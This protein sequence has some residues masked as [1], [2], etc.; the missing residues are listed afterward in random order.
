MRYLID[1]CSAETYTSFS[2]DS[3]KTVAY[4]KD[5]QRKL[6]SKVQSGDILISY[7]MKL[8]RW[9][10]YQEVVRESHDDPKTIGKPWVIY[11]GVKTHVW[12]QSV[13]RMLPI[14]LPEIWDKLSFTKG[15]TRSEPAIGP[16]RRSLQE[17]N[18]EDGKLLIRL[19]NEQQRLQWPY[20][21]NN[22][23]WEAQ[24]KSTPRLKSK[25]KM[26]KQRGGNAPTNRPF[27]YWVEGKRMVEPRHDYLQERF[28]EYLWDQ[29]INPK[30]DVDFIDVQYSASGRTTFCEIKPTENVPTRYAIRAAI[31]QLLEHRFKQSP[32]AALEIV[33]GSKPGQEE[34]DFVNS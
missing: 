23:A 20:P 13:D 7:L 26:H 25:R 4:F 17:I 10:G 34:S 1:L 31:G 14:K 3:S 16:V 33:I 30:Q 8:R 21:I 28:V 22:A 29:G 2:D 32:K 9:I 5:N 12:L 27:E 19:L 15:K 11:F 6:A 24:F 18:Q